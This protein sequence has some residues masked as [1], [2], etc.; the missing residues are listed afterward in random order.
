MLAQ[1]EGLTLLFVPKL[2]AK[3]THA[4]LVAAEDP[5]SGYFED[6]KVTHFPIEASDLEATGERLAGL[7][8]GLEKE[9]FRSLFR[10]SEGWTGEDH[11]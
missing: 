7:G 9:D 1:Q 3:S 5:G 6:A 4:I 11:G 10:I 8:D 2:T